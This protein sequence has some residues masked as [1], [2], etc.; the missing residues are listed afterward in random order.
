MENKNKILIVSGILLVIVV[1]AVFFYFKSKNAPP[2]QTSV[3]NNNV[4]STGN[5]ANVPQINIPQIQTP[6][7]VTNSGRSNAISY[8]DPTQPFATL[9]PRQQIPV[10]QKNPAVQTNVQQAPPQPAQAPNIDPSDI[11]N[12]DYTQLSDSQFLAKYY[13][14][15]QQVIDGTTAADFAANAED[16]VLINDNSPA[17]GA[18]GGVIPDNPNVNDNLFNISQNTDVN[19][20]NTFIQ[21]LSDTTSNF[22]LVHNNAL[23]TDVLNTLDQNQIATLNQQAQD[24]INQMQKI[25]VPANMLGLEKDY[26]AYY[27]EYQVYLSDLN[28]LVNT[29][30]SKDTSQLS[31]QSG[32]L[33]NDVSDLSTTLGNIN[34]DIEIARSIVGGN[35]LSTLNIQ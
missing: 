10:R 11:T 16:P 28:T 29:S 19:S 6:V 15:Y 24:A 26:Y 31:N 25:T 14:D 18:I 34:Q 17:A 27:K 21:D 33:Q 4:S 3:L 8:V 32:V 9:L 20:D 2:S 12:P 5:V 30:N 7:P 22:D 13:P 23:F 1:I 35:D